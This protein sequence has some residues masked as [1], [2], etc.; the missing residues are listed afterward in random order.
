MIKPHADI[1]QKVFVVEDDASLREGICDLLHSLG[2]GT[3]D[4]HSAEEFLARWNLNMAGCLVLDVRLPGMSGMELHGKLAELSPT[5]P[6]II[7]TAHGDMPMVRK[8]LKTGASEFL[9]KPFPN[10]ELLSAV[11]HALDLDRQ[12]RRAASLIGSI[13]TRAKALTERERQVF[14][15]VTAGMM[16]KEMADRLQV[17]VVTIKMHR[18]QVMKKMHAESL[19]DLVT[20]WGLVH[21]NSTRGRLLS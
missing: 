21:P 8:A 20:M 5:I 3:E 14:E 15:L 18:G 11:E 17:S 13:E 10:E 19:A 9:I 16:N 4:Y 12:Q 2:I 7:M 1:D 6:I